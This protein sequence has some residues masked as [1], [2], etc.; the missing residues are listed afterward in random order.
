LSWGRE[1]KPF[2]K[3]QWVVYYH[4]SSGEYLMKVMAESMCEDFKKKSFI[5]EVC[6]DGRKGG[7]AESEE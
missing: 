7:A 4:V 5:L 2:F 6:V 3:G 1:N